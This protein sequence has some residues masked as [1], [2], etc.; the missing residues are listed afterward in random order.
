MR[1]RRVT[2]L[3]AAAL[4]VAAC[5]PGA[6]PPSSASP[7]AEAVRSTG[8]VPSS[9]TPTTA[10]PPVPS[11]PSS[12]G[13]GLSPEFVGTVFPI[14]A[15]E[16]AVGQ[17]GFG[18]SFARVQFDFLAAC[19]DSLGYREIAEET[20]NL[21]LYYP[22]PGEAWRLPDLARLREKGFDSRGSGDVQ[23]IW[24]SSY[25]NPPKNTLGPDPA[26]IE[27]QTNPQW[28]LSAEQRD[29]VVRDLAG[30][31]DA[32]LNIDQPPVFQVVDQLSGDWLGTLDSLDQDPAIQQL[33][34]D[35]MDCARR[36]DPAFAD[37][38]DPQHWLTIETGRQ[39]TMDN[40]I[41]TDWDVYHQTLIDWGRAWADC[42]EPVVTA[43]L[44]LR[45]A[46]RSERIDRDYPQLLELQDQ[47]TH[48]LQQ[49]KD[50]AEAAAHQ[51]D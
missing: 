39:A 24:F 26:T 40:D 15:A 46:A 50:A 19:A 44:P 12:V 37:A 5:V 1:R 33:I 27:L 42:I 35:V 10:P 4:V 32:F 36:I 23:D 48:A 25:G 29:V 20:R 45:T 49:W 7:D 8:A 31:I 51:G 14:D 2:V 41:N 9:V 47:L 38:R 3:V 17:T 13:S 28:G 21:D 11:S 34:P 6:S 22:D 30:C 18:V 16:Y 43:R